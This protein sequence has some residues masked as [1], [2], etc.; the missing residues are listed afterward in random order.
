MLCLTYVYA[1]KSIHQYYL[2][3]NQAN[4][5]KYI[6]YIYYMDDLLNFNSIFAIY[7]VINM[8]N[9]ELLKTYV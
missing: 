8:N 9:R 4:V 6:A 5:F 1:C 2:L 3:L 7:Y